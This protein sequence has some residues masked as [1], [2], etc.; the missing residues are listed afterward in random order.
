M[1][2]GA[3]SPGGPSAAPEVQTLGS[4]PGSTTVARGREASGTAAATNADTPSG[5]QPG[6]PPELAEDGPVRDSRDPL[7][8]TRLGITLRGLRR[9]RR[10]LEEHFGGPDAF[11][12]VSTADVNFKWVRPVT[13]DRACRLLEA[14]EEVAAEDVAPP[15]YFVSHAWK[16][17]LALLLDYL[18]SFLAAA[19]DTT[20]VWIDILAVNQHEKTEQQKHDIGAFSAVVAACSAGTIVVLDIANCNP[21]TRGWCI[22]EWAH[23][24][25]AHGP[26]GLH[27]A[28]TPADRAMICNTLDVTKAECQYPA[29]K[30]MILEVVTRQHGSTDAFNHK[31]RLQL[32]LEPLSY[33]VDMRRLLRRAEAAGTRWA[34]GPV[35]EWLAEPHATAPRVLCVAAG[36]GEGKSTISAALC[37]ASAPDA[38]ATAEATGAAATAATAT[39]QLPAGAVCGYHFLKYNDQRRLDAVNIIKSLAFQLAIRLP[40]VRDLIYHQSAMVPHLLDPR[41]A[42]EALLLNPLRWYEHMLQSAKDAAMERAKLTAKAAELAEAVVS[43][44]EAEAEAATAAAAAAEAAAATDALEKLQLVLLI[45][46]LDEADPLPEQLQIPQRE[47]AAAQGALAAAGASRSAA[48]SNGTTAAAAIASSAGAAAAA[49]GAAA[50]AAA[51]ASPP[52][53]YPTACGNSALH[54]LTSML[55]QLPSFVRFIVTTRP[56]AAFGQVL[57]SLQRAFKPHNG[58]RLLR[59]QQLVAAAE[60][61]E[62]AAP[63][64]AEE[65]PAAEA[66][67]SDG[68]GDGVGDGGSGAVMVYSTVAAA[69]L[70]PGSPA[71]S[72][73]APS[74]PDLYRLY[75]SIFDDAWRRLESDAVRRDVHDLLGVVLAAQEPLSHSLLQQMGLGHV[76]ALLPGYPHLFY[77]D[78]HHLYTIH[79]SLADWLA[80][81]GGGGGVDAAI[82]PGLVATFPRPDVLGAHLRLGSALASFRHAAATAPPYLVNYLIHHLA[83]AAGSASDAHFTVGGSGGAP[84]ED[85]ATR[86]GA[87]AEQAGALLDEVLADFRFLELVLARGRG[88]AIAESLGSMRRRTALSNDVLR[89]LSAHMQELQANPKSALESAQAHCPLTSR[90]YRTAVA[91]AGTP[92]APRLVVPFRPPASEWPAMTARLRDAGSTE[93]NGSSID[94]AAWSPDCRQVAMAGGAMVMAEHNSPQQHQHVHTG[95]VHVYD[96]VTCRLRCSLVIPGAVPDNFVTALDWSRDGRLIVTV[97]QADKMVRWWDV[98]TGQCV[99]WA[100]GRHDGAFTAVALHPTTAACASAGSK[101]SSGGAESEVLMCERPPPSGGASMPDAE[102]QQMPHTRLCGG[103]YGG[104]TGLAFSPDGAMLAAAHASGVLLVYGGLPPYPLL[105]ALWL[106]PSSTQATTAQPHHQPG[107]SSSLGAAP[108]SMC[109]TMW[110]V[111]FSGDSRFLAVSGLGR[112]ASV[113]DT[114]RSWQHVAHLMT[115]RTKAGGYVSFSGSNTKVAAGD[116]AG[117][118]WVYDV[119]QLY[120]FSTDGSN[121]LRSD[122][123]S[124]AGLPVPPMQTNNGGSPAGAVVAGA[125]ST[126][127]GLAAPMPPP[128]KPV[129][130]PAFTSLEAGSK[131]DE[132]YGRLLWAPAP[133][134]ELLACCSRGG[135][136]CV[137]NMALVG[138]EAAPSEVPA[139]ARSPLHGTSDLP[140]FGLKVSPDGE[141]VVACS[142]DNVLVIHSTRTWVREA[143]VPSG[144]D[145]LFFAAWSPCGRWLLA[146][147]SDKDELRVFGRDGGGADGSSAWAVRR[148]VRGRQCLFWQTLHGGPLLLAAISDHACVRL[149]NVSS[150]PDDPAGWAELPSHTLGTHEFLHSDP[151]IMATSHD[152]SVLAVGVSGLAVHF[153][154]GAA[155]FRH[156]G[157]VSLYGQ[158]SETLEFNG[159]AWLPPSASGGVVGNFG[160]VGSVTAA[161]AGGVLRLAL[162]GAMHNEVVVYEVRNDLAAALELPSLPTSPSAAAASEP[163]AAAPAPERGARQLPLFVRRQLGLRG[164]HLMFT[165]LAVSPDGRWLASG[166]LDKCVRIYDTATGQQAGSTLSG[167]HEAMVVSL[168]FAPDGGGLYSLDGDGRLVVMVPG[169]AL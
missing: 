66:P 139:A 120:D 95:A 93:T 164:P 82:T 147:G 62:A 103:E 10:R 73:M 12:A 76:I 68:G 154:D 104:C 132:A 6:G 46:G 11:S 2:C 75:G 28:L 78:E 1:G 167:I 27:M 163:A 159:M 52:A 160:R 8:T 100:L 155:P 20:A 69:C 122:P 42:F 70:P 89:W 5:H 26:D 105:R 41:T 55:R 60:A 152:G 44:E 135:A 112:A 91:A 115:G 63:S 71:A 143:V 92:W 67:G 128:P 51:A 158:S 151:C 101:G 15:S 88:P 87:V 141:R 57:P 86:V 77:I 162:I 43:R 136:V 124:L 118:V 144:C 125:D 133:G 146:A 39:Q 108:E 64:L 53:V 45:D 34:F 138:A 19:A 83:A 22:F 117:V 119:S 85:G 56:D 33:T 29:D 49:S 110:G 7:E 111:A 148:V 130:I 37:A 131:L 106:L 50:A 113:F 23:T 94:A 40:V 107:D 165:A 79:K 72:L 129:S 114:K 65:S 169:A 58:V 150:S 116:D 96:T 149:Y 140:L 134:T 102:A 142:A 36:V 59:P 13:A 54:V 156:R 16:N 168:Q 109:S 74:L 35:A 90:L 31:L 61:A 145:G 17:S 161:T 14:R 21:S 4:A 157:S 99:G 127:G 97:S 153:F 25:S 32:L 166:S 126:D 98:V 24:L 81:A 30:D 123:A 3:S 80:A 9:L 84:N 38:T 47:Q 121:P 18:D 137:Y 48:R